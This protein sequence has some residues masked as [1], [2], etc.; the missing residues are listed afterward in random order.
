MLNC[1]DKMAERCYARFVP[2]NLNIVNIPWFQSS[3]IYSGHVS[4]SIFQCSVE[5]S[6]LSLYM[7]GFPFISS[8]QFYSRH[9]WSYQESTQQLKLVK[10]EFQLK[11]S[12]RNR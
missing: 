3:L 11:N 12:A 4:L 10:I 7:G 6:Y 2:F 5:L 1:D 9:V 8:L